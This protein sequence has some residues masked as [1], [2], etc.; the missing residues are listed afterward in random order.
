MEDLSHVGSTVGNFQMRNEDAILK[1]ENLTK[2]YTTGY[3]F[4][5]KVVGAEDVSFTLKR[6]E[7]LSLVGES[8]SGK[9]TTAKMILRLIKPSSGRILLD[10]RDAYSFEGREYWRRVQ[11]VFQDPYS[12]FNYFYT[13]DRPLMDAFDLLEKTS[14]KTYTQAEREETVASTL[15]TID[16]N[17]DEIL[18]RF[19]HQLSGGQMQR[20]LIARSLIIG[21]EVLLADEPTSM[22]DASTRVAILNELLRLKE[23]ERMAV[24]FISHDV[25][26][27]YYVSDRVAV[28]QK[29]RIVE[30]G[31]VEEVFFEPEHPYVRDLVASVPKLYEKW[32]L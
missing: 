27:A 31:P 29:G 17:P 25:G 4:R 3:I 14:S 1:V 23:E 28:M 21:P 2:H 11:A 12:T 9:T 8:G 13:V 6:G 22:T 19:P 20:L 16:M 15:E 18:G 10:G 30:M 32:N 24:I 5:R 7:I 26:Q